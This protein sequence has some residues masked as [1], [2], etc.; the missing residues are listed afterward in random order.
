MSQLLKNPYGS[1]TSFVGRLQG[2]HLKEDSNRDYKNSLAQDRDMGR[3]ATQVKMT[4]GKSMDADL[5]VKGYHFSIGSLPREVQVSEIGV[6][7]EPDKFLN[8]HDPD[9]KPYKL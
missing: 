1:L 3:K 5:N 7:A 9:L 2:T 6:N 4:K 8:L